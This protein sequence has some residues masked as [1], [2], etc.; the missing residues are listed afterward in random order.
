MGYTPW[1]GNT[2]VPS[3]SQWYN[4]IIPHFL[5]C[6]WQE[7]T[8]SGCETFRLERRPTQNCEGYQSP[9]VASIDS[10]NSITTFD[11]VNYTFNGEGDYVLVQ[12]S[13]EDRFEVQG[14]FQQVQDFYTGVTQL[15]SVTARGNSNTVI[16]IRRRPEVARWR[17]RLDVFAD[18]RRVYFDKA[19]LKSQN[20]PGVTVYT[21]SYN[22]DQ[23]EVIV[24]FDSGAGVEVSESNGYLTTRVYL[25]ATF[26]VLILK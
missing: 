24:M 13:T 16:E 20:F 7:E 23:S 10:Y 2:K 21:P 17:Y 15:T 6:R 3:L 25:P 1:D 11:N 5:C 19:S 18:A 26:M 4:D 8:S 14:R 22:Y 9:G 12:S